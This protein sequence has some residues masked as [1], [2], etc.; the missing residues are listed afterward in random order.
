[1]SAEWMTLD[2]KHLLNYQ[3]STYRKIKIWTI[4]KETTRRTQ[5]WGRNRSFIG[6]P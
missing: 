2:T 5:S 1:M 4:I 6:L 3:L